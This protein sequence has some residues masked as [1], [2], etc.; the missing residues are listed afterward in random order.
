MD[1]DGAV[2]RPPLD[3]NP[4][5]GPAVAMPEPGSV[6]PGTGLFVSG[7]DGLVLFATLRTR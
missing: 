7:L 5:P 6:E 4:S 2:P 1:A 3:P